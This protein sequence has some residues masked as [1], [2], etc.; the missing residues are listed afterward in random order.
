MKKIEAGQIYLQIDARLYGIYDEKKRYVRVVREHK[1]VHC[2]LV[3]FCDIGLN[4]PSD[5]DLNQIHEYIRSYFIR[6]YKYIAP[7]EYDFELKK[8]LDEEIIKEIIE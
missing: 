1:T 2:D 4:Q 6:D 5:I 8:I 7:E 3:L